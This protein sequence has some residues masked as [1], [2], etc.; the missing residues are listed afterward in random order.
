MHRRSRLPLV[1]L[2]TLLAAAGLAAQAARTAIAPGER[3][4][5]IDKVLSEAVSRGDV[6]GVV[7]LVHR[8]RLV[9]TLSATSPSLPMVGT[10]GALDS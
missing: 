4:R 6:P 5:A 7:A 1:V 3:A 8:G 9:E 2:L 10:S